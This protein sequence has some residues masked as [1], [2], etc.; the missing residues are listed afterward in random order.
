MNLSEI[1]WVPFRLSLQVGCLA[2]LICF[3][4]GIPLSWWIARAHPVLS[5]ALSTIVLA[6]L[7]LPPTAM[8]YY[9][10]YILGR[11]SA[12]GRFLI[13]DLGVRLI[14]TWQGAGL[15]AAIVALPLFVRTA[16]A[17]FEHVNP[18]LLDVARTLVPNRLVFFRVALP[19]AWPSIAAATLIAFARGVGEF[20]ATVIVA[21]NIPGRTQ[22]VPVAIYDAVQAGNTELANTLV[23]VLML[24]SIGLLAAL[25]YF[26]YRAR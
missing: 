9:L 4:I 25:A 13:D 12:F 24:S 21:G 22:T 16:Q 15:A 11:Q 10:L 1:A 3:M 23:F 26:L 6:P 5:G 2:T 18:D 19:L 20:G 14:F 8:G 17:G 7:V